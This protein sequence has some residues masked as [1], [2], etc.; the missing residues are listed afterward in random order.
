MALRNP[1]ATLEYTIIDRFGREGK[2]GFSSVEVNVATFPD[3]LL[4]VGDFRDSI[5]LISGGTV[6]KE[7]YSPYVERMSIILPTSVDFQRERKWQLICQDDVNFKTVEL[8]IPCARVTG[9]ND[10]TLGFDLVDSLGHANMAH[11]DWVDVKNRIANICRSIDGNTITLI[12]AVLITV[13]T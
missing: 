9:S 13:N 8:S 3:F 2:F 5:A 4:A 11:Q 12:D 7:E 1:D 6:V 10:P